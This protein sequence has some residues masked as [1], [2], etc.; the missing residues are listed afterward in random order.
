MVV[1]RLLTILVSSSFRD[2]F[3]VPGAHPRKQNG[4]AYNALPALR[5]LHCDEI[6]AIGPHTNR[7]AP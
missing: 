5:D 4:K 7:G 3:R 1:C 6:L 2:I